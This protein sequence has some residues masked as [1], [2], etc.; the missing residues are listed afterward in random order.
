MSRFYLPCARAMH[1][2]SFCGTLFVA[3]QKI[4]SDDPMPAPDDSRAGRIAFTHPDFVLFQIARFLIVAAVEMQ[5]VAVGWQVY[6]ITKRALDL[7]LVGLA[8]FLP[9]ILLFLVSGHT[10]DRFER[11]RVLGACYAGYA[12]CSGLLLFLAERGTHSVRPIYAVLILLGVVR[13]FN[14]TASRSILPQLVPEEHFA[15][16]VAWNAT[17]F[18]AATILGPSLGGILYQLFH[19]PTAVYAGAMLTAVGALL[20]MFRIKTRP[21]ARRREPMTAKTIL[22]GLHFIWR[23]KLVLGAISLDLFAVLLGGAVALLPVYAREILHT[24]P[25]GLGLLRTAP[26]VGAALMAVALAHRP[27]RGRAGPTLLWSVAGFGICTIIFGIS[28][29]LML[30]LISLIL[31]GAADMVSVI[32]R[33]TLVQLRT[34]DEM[35]GRVMAVDMVFIGTSN[36]LGQFESGLTAQWFGAVPAVLLGGVGTLVVIALWAWKFPELRR[37]GEF[38]AMKSVTEETAEAAERIH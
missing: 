2:L 22:A 35:R 17:T 36:E 15:N 14:G 31:L 11:R 30:S 16:A 5:A 21:Q 24:G 20:S 25:W 7:G 38:S 34:P 19:G 10:S 18:Q 23:E 33:A 1:V 8:Q 6:D 12:L 28:R 27:L 13:S 3:H 37:A 4:T 26:G 32:I 29:S 9:G